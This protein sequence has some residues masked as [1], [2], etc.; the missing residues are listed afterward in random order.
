MNGYDAIAR[1]DS[2]LQRKSAIEIRD[3]DNS[4]G[5][6]PGQALDPT[7]H[8]SLQRRNPR[9]KGPTMRR[10]HDWDAEGPA[11]EP[12][13]N[14]CLRRVYGEKVRIDVPQCSPDFPQCPEILYRSYGDRQVTKDRD[15]NPF[16]S[17]RFDEGAA[18]P[19]YD[20]GLVTLVSDGHCQISDMNLG[21][22]DRL[23][24]RDQ[25]GDSHAALL[26]R[27]R[28]T[29]KRLPWMRCGRKMVGLVLKAS[30]RDPAFIG[31]WQI[32]QRAFS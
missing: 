25:I 5:K 22:A 29:I 32:A 7:V 6:R 16:G 18:A 26:L 10:K 2:R 27:D 11:C 17:E 21:S 20:C 1:C 23:G 9:R 14:S 28:H 24:P 3:R 4:V 8:R 19:G 31:R 15:R 13:K 30:A 12:A